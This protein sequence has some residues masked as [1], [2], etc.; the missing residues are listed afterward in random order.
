MKVGES[1]GVHISDSK[2]P[3]WSCCQPHHG[4]VFQQLTANGTGSHLPGQSCCSSPCTGCLL[5]SLSGT[6]T[7]TSTHHQVFLVAQLL[8][9]GGPKD[10]NLSI[11]ASAP[12]LGQRS[13]VSMGGH[14]I[15]SAWELP[16]T[17]SHRGTIL[18]C[19]L[20]G[21]LQFQ[22]LQGIKIQP[23]IQGQELPSDGLG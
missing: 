15:P 6:V 10:S 2:V 11:V 19:E 5:C 3:T 12:L 14:S 8:L 20:H 18:L 9:E 17:H 16:G 7:A 13:Y 1:D 22:A 21:L 23:L 4:K